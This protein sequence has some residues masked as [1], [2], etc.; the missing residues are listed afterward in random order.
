MRHDSY[1]KMHDLETWDDFR[2]ALA[3]R[4]AG[5]LSGAARLLRVNQSTVSRALQR[6]EQR[7]GRPLFLNLAGEYRP[8]PGAEPMLEIA[9]QM[10]QLVEGLRWP[11]EGAGISETVRMTSVEAVVVGYLAPKLAEFRSR[12]PSIQLE[13]NGSNET[14]NLLR[15]NFDVAL[16]LERERKQGNLV[17]KKLAE[18]GIGV[19]GHAAS[20]MGAWI[21]YE[22]SLAGI[23]EEKWLRKE[24]KGETPRLRV[25]S[26]LSM[27]R[28]IQE[29]LGI[30]LLPF[31]MGDKNPQLVRQSGTKPVVTR[32]LWFIAHPEARRRPGVARFREWL[33]GE[34]KRDESLRGRE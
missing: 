5:T 1:A 7:W 6:L 18:F 13:L 10:D 19:Y 26:Y 27:E 16:R 2:L 33:V 25:G 21:G 22:A 31:F 24:L 23:P 29:G 34:L 11:A 3:I 20:P 14:F 12:Y 17:Q 30:G 15:R 4:K 28:A 8:T 9:K 32:A